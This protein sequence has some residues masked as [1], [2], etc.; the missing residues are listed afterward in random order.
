MPYEL[1]T[2]SYGKSRVRLTKV[3]RDG[4]VQQITELSVDV[5]LDGDF[6]GA[7]TD[8][9]NALVVPTD[10]MKNTVY[11][12][13]RELDAYELE[14]IAWTLGSHFIEAFDHIS[15]VYVKISETPWERAELDGQPHSHVFLGTSSER[16]TCQ[17]GM[18]RSPDGEEPEGAIECG[19]EGLIL[20]KTTDSG[21]SMFLQDEFTTLAETDDRIMATNV[22]AKW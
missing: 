7:Y 11:A 1:L 15:D 21:F 22:T 14:T 20:L 13:S 8:G 17:V 5:E 3:D 18:S 10:T 2:Q 19:L 9:D 16:H 6:S 4:E 12:F